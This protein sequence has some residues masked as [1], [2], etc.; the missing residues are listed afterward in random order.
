MLWKNRASSRYLLFTFL[1]SFVPTAFLPV[2]CEYTDCRWMVGTVGHIHGLHLGHQTQK[3]PSDPLLVFWKSA[4]T[5]TV[6][7]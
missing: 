2:L 1:V 3:K 4:H 7:Y 6:V 5:Q